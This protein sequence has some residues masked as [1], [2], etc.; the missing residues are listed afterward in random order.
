MASLPVYDKSGKEVGK[1]DINPDDLAKSI[2][3]QLLHDVVVMYQANRRQGSHQTKSRSDVSGS[4]KKLYRQK[5]TGN[6]RAGSRRSNVRRGGGH[7]FAKSNR[8]YSYRLP[9]KAVRL[10]TRMAMAGKIQDEQVL[11][12][13]D[14]SMDQPQTKQI[15]TL[16]KALGLNDKSALI[17]TAQHDP[18][19][20]KSARNIGG[21]SVTR[22]SDLNALEILRPHRVLM[23]RDA[24]DAFKEQAG[25]A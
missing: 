13:D 3:K 25:T 10:A 19:V 4:T 24:M 16:L 17:A 1:Y 18:V 20:Y 21:V 12:I 6:A 23:T 5:G 11:V 7:A 14:L 9:R 22:V 8:D 2:N 15:A